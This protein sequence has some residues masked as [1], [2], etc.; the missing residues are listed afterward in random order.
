MLFERVAVAA[1]AA[2]TEH[3]PIVDDYRLGFREQH[4]ADLLPAIRQQP[5][6]AVRFDNRHVAAEPGRMPAAGRET[7]A[8]G[9]PITAL[10]RNGPAGAG[11]IRSPGEDAVRTA[12]TF[13]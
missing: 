5:R 10:D 1:G 3:V 12:K 9:N 4:R 7:P 6:R 11:Q 13:E 8:S 2:Q